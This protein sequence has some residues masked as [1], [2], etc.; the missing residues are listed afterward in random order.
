ML[1][2]VYQEF[3]YHSVVATTN[4]YIQQ[5][6]YLIYDGYDNVGYQ[7]G[8]ENLNHFHYVAPYD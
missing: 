7:Y 5:L 8:T 6:G 2:F 4:D 1:V 3:G